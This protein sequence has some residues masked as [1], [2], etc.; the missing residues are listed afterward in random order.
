MSSIIKAVVTNNEGIHARTTAA[1]LNIV[2]KYNADAYIKYREQTVNLKHIIE[3]IALSVGHDATFEIII[4]GQES[5]A[6]AEELS[7]FINNNLG[8][9]L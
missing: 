6:C 8:V 7:I 9:I 1:F 3:V 5:S 4:D 2:N